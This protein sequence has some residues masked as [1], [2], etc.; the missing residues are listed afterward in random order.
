[1]KKFFAALCLISRSNGAPPP[2]KLETKPASIAVK[3]V[4]S[5]GAALVVP[6][7]SAPTSSK[8]EAPA[9]QPKALT[10]PGSVFVLDDV[11]SHPDPAMVRKINAQIRS[12]KTA[13]GCETF[14]AS[15]AFIS[16]A[17]LKKGE[18][19]DPI[20]SRTAGGSYD[21]A[22]TYNFV[23]QN[24]EFIPVTAE[25]VFADIE[26]ATDLAWKNEY[27]R[28]AS[29]MSGAID[30]KAFIITE[31]G[32][33]F[34]SD[35]HPSETTPETQ[36]KFEEHPK[37]F[38]LEKAP[39]SSLR[40][41]QPLPGI[42]E[43]QAYAQ[44]IEQLPFDAKNIPAGM[45]VYGAVVAGAHWMDSAGENYLFVTEREAKSKKD[46]SLLSRYV[47]AYHF[48]V[49]LPTS[50]PASAPAST[51]TSA[52]ASAPAITNVRSVFT[53][54]ENCATTNHA[55]F[56]KDS[57]LVTDY[58]L[59]NIGEVSFAA[60]LGCGDASLSVYLLE[61]GGKYSLTGEASGLVQNG[62][63][64][65]V[66]ASFLQFLELRWSQLSAPTPTSAP[67]GDVRAPEH[68]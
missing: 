17:C 4:T 20:E 5:Q 45:T 30:D 60:T 32:V 34:Y 33:L 13:L 8:I 66:S 47:N 31:D 44:L 37:L 38:H 18:Y 64:Q 3:P 46:P 29:M 48:R 55:A 42:E 67:S 54:E 63:F 21:L 11:E 41:M 27:F 15:S 9:S 26:A 16:F 39:L 28:D 2:N 6:P 49:T 7:K 22:T 23:I 10:I 24:G 40:K 56:V 61:A 12:F 14:L 50:M 43:T 52:P 25:D 35:R 36:L 58:D 1:M 59:D 51:P 68:P 65:N 19:I 62:P 53:K 57:I